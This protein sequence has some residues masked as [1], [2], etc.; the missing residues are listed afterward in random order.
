MIALADGICDILCGLHP[1]AVSDYQG[2][3][4]IDLSLAVVESLTGNFLRLVKRLHSSL[5]C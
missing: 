1:D 5:L 2:G 3:A 4:E